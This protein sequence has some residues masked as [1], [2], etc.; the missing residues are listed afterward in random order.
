M[1]I[2]AVVV[3]P[4][5]HDRDNDHQNIVVREFS[6]AYVRVGRVVW[7]SDSLQ[8]TNTCSRVCVYCAVCRLRIE[9]DG[10]F[11]PNGC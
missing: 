6:V 1:Q 7:C 10:F 3:I 5:L 9:S 4:Q 8:A 2:N 11:F